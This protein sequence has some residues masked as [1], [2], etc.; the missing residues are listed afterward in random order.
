MIDGIVSS[1]AQ[2]A[3]GRAA[4]WNCLKRMGKG[5]QRKAGRYGMAGFKNADSLVR[6]AGSHW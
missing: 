5:S 4:F 1:A 2:P 6:T 3:G